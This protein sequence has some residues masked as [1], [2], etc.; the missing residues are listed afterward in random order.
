MAVSRRLFLHRIGAVGGYAAAYSAMHALGLMPAAAQAAPALSAD[1]GRGKRVVILGAGV[2]GL[3]AAYELERAG[4]AVTVLEARGRVGGR[5]WTLRGGDKVEMVGEADQTV[6]FSDGLYLNAGP[7]RIPSHHEALLGYCRKLGVAMEVEVNS[8]RSAYIWSEGSNG[9]RPIQMRQGLNDTRGYMS[10]LLAKAINRGALDQD[11]TLEDKEKLLPFLRHYGDL[12][13]D[14]TFKGTERSGF[15]E[16]PGAADKFARKRDPLPLK[17]LLNNGQLG[18]TVFEDSLYMQAT[19]FQP[20]GGMDRIPAAFEKAIES[21]IVRNA[22][23]TRIRDTAAGVAVSYR[24]RL[25]GAEARLDADYAVITIPLAVLKGI[26]ANFAAPVKQA[27]AAVPNDF[28]NKIG[29]DAPRFWE[30]EQIF[31]GISFVGG[32]TGLIWYPSAGLFAERGM[33]LACYS[34]GRRAEA[35]A[36]KP[37]GEQ[38][39]AARAAVGRVHPGRDG[40][41]ERPVVV[42]WSKVPFSL[43]PWPTWEGR[44]AQEGHLDTE[45]Y[46][47]LN[48]PHGRTYF[49]G[50]HLSQM[51]GW[52][53][54][55]VL[56][57]H[58]AIG[59]LADRV[60]Q[61]AAVEPTRRRQGAA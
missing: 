16:L 26:D 61:S 24:D 4:F 36:R 56:S 40:D 50:G 9:G 43:G 45:P 39:A 14:L 27:I 38:I 29:F 19:M 52:Q 18:S 55:A 3:V 48:Q 41:L 49:A 46:R 53:E 60:A 44:S 13:P 15:A 47:L 2:T 31:G 20:V 34:S 30:K 21:P 1:V 35:F 37:L 10:E 58:R 12:A 28:S 5:N 25:S 7:A 8:S 22:V 11:L 59:L 23:V 32:E 6:G 54:G 42:N 57:A 51:P 33:L 17:E